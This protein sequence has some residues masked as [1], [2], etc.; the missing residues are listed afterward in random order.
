MVGKMERQKSKLN[1][2]A[3]KQKRAEFRKAKRRL[4]LGVGKPNDPIVIIRL[5]KELGYTKVVQ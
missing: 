5:A 1:N 2:H 3:I 4:E